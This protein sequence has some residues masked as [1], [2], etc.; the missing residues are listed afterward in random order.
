VSRK[1][2]TEFG[3][4]T[5]SV[6]RGWTHVAFLLEEFERLASASLLRS[7]LSSDI[8]LPADVLLDMASPL[9]VNEEVRRFMS[10]SSPALLLLMCDVDIF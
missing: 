10:S 4:S 1:K 2:K 8:I 7:L 9:L 6:N 5:S 3:K